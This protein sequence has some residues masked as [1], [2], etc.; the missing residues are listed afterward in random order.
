MDGGPTRTVRSWPLGE[1]EKEEQ[2]AAD[3][4]PFPS[5]IFF[6]SWLQSSGGINNIASIGPNSPPP[7][8]DCVASVFASP[9]PVIYFF[10]ALVPTF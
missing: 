10:F 9:S 7:P 5:C 1:G 4:L 2:I 6:L 3:I 8:L